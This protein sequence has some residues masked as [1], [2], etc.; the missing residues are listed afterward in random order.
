[1]SVLDIIQS[2]REIT[3]FLEKKIP[4]E[5]LKQIAEAAYY[6]PSGNNLLSREFIMIENRE[7]LDH[8]EK[9]TPFMKWMSTAQAA[10]VVTGRPNTSKYWLQ[11]ASIATAF[12]WLAASDLNIGVGFGAV[13]HAED[14][15]ESSVRETHVRKAL[16]IPADRRIVAILGLG[17]PAENPKKKKMLNRQDT[18]FYETFSVDH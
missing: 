17:F 10:I 14:E 15:E 18:V 5:V 4:K 3:S 12:I 16:N 6:A 7:M 13:Y 8:L 2:R 9:T 1:M 11:D